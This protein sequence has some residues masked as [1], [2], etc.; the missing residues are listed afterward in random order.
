MSCVSS[1]YVYICKI[2][3][4]PQPNNVLNGRHC[5]GHCFIY[6]YAREHIIVLYFSIQDFSLF[7]CY[8]AIWHG[9]NME[10]P[11]NSVGHY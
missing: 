2:S 3:D 11:K 1:R 9:M 8:S 6:T 4:R 7:V 5:V 10:K